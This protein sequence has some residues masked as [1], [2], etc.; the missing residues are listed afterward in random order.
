MRRFWD[1][2]D[3]GSSITGSAQAPGYT[4]MYVPRG[5]AAVRIVSY[6]ARAGAQKASLLTTKGEL[7]TWGV[8][9]LITLIIT[10]ITIIQLK[11]LNPHT[12]SH[13]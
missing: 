10:N 5:G 6:S 12:Q 3:S 2:D 9:L 11:K 1:R 13:H 4:D 7:G 8:D